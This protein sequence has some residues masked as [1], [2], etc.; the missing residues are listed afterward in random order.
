[1]AVDYTKNALR[2]Y[3]LESKSAPHL[4][5][6]CIILQLPHAL[7]NKLWLV[8]VFHGLNKKVQYRP[9]RPPNTL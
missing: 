3:V 5:L 4:L 7:E 1:M 2:P 8:L 9:P 6:P